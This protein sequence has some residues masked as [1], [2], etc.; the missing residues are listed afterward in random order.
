MACT[1]DDSFIPSFLHFFLNNK[2]LG[3][4]THFGEL[5]LLKDGGRRMA[6]VRAKTFCD[7]STLSRE[8]FEEVNIKCILYKKRIMTL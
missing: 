1:F 3:P 8:D 6:T 4:G 2:V 5:A 7:L